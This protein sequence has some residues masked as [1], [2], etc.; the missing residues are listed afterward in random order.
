L[1]R[2]QDITQYT[3]GK[4][5]CTRSAV[6]SYILLGKIQN[7]DSS[8]FL[9]LV[10]E[11]LTTQLF[12]EHLTGATVSQTML[13]VGEIIFESKENLL[14]KTNAFTFLIVLVQET[15]QQMLAQ[16]H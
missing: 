4:L 8:R 14:T 6:L 10:Y 12:K 1:P 11:L 5:A 16:T 15:D 2:F 3:Y 13:H 9:N 7:G